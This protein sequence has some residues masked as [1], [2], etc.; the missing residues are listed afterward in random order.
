MY[1]TT[2]KTTALTRQTFVGKVI[3]MLFNMLYRFVIAF[4]PRGKHVLISWLQ[5]PP[6]IS[7]PN[8]IKSVIVST[9]PHLFS[10]MWWDWVPWSQFFECW[11]LS[12]LFHSPLL[13]PLNSSLV[14]NTNNTHYLVFGTTRFAVSKEDLTLGPKTVSV[15]QSFV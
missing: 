4:L 13:P 12:Q 3:S 7:E 14:P 11:V 9:F 2:G 15:T 1:M 6:V 5:S 8:K 10:I